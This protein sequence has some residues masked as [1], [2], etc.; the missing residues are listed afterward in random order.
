MSLFIKQLNGH[1]ID[2]EFDSNMTIYG[3]KSRVEK[4]TSIP[5][6]DLRLIY[7]GKA[8]SDDEKKLSD[9]GL[10]KDTSIYLVTRTVTR[11][12]VSNGGGFANSDASPASDEKKVAKDLLKPP[13]DDG[14]DPENSYAFII[15]N[16]RKNKD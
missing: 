2:I 7:A 3:V 14:S 16:G 8:L 13:R 6:C 11:P 9:Y 5:V 12:N 10:Q 4:S 15:C 1:V